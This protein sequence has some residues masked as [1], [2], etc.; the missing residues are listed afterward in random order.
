[1]AVVV[2]AVFA[3]KYIYTDLNSKPKLYLENGYS[4]ETLRQFFAETKQF[5]YDI[6]TNLLLILTEHWCHD[7]ANEDCEPYKF[8]KYSDQYSISFHA[9]QIILSET[10]YYRADFYKNLEIYLRLG[11]LGKAIKLSKAAPNQDADIIVNLFD[12]IKSKNLDASIETCGLKGIYEGDL[13]RGAVFNLPILPSVKFENH[14]CGNWLMKRFSGLIHYKRTGFSSTN[15]AH[16]KI[17]LALELYFIEWLRSNDF[18]LE[19][20]DDLIEKISE[21]FDYFIDKY[22]T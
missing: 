2:A 8:Y 5:E 17:Q 21:Y 12:N 16:N 14:L 4:K 11:I 9:S 22:T 3:A 19:N 6:K 20:T 15:K 18:K 1:M 10:T 7:S 13:Y